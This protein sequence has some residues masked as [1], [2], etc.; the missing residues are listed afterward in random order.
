LITI[1]AGQT[2]FIA[3]EEAILR[4]AAR[5]IEEAAARFDD[6][7]LADF[8]RR[9]ITDRGVLA[10]VLPHVSEGVRNRTEAKS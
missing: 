5:H 9:D 1:V 10:A 7:E 2:Q 6:A 8:I 3:S 4:V